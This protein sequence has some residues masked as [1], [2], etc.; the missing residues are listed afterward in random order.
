MIS[1]SS[2]LL[3]N[4]VAV[5]LA[6]LHSGDYVWSSALQTSSLSLEAYVLSRW[7]KNLTVH[8]SQAMDTFT[9]AR[10]LAGDLDVL[11]VQGEC[12]SGRTAVGPPRN[13]GLE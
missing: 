8:P 1:L 7:V 10:V 6:V 9:A 11:G 5:E 3:S 4:A 13:A 2:K 12:G